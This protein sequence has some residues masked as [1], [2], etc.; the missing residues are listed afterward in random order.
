MAPVPQRRAIPRWF[1][2]L[3]VRSPTCPKNKD[4]L[5]SRF[6]LGLQGVRWSGRQDSNLRPLGPEGPNADPHGLVPGHLASY[7]F[8]N[9]WV[10]GDAGS[11]TVAP[12]PP[13][14]TPF[15]ALVVHDAVGRLLT[16]REV[17]ARLR[18][19]RATVYRLVRAGA[20]PVLRV[21]NA[22]RIPA[23]ALARG[24]LP[25]K[26]AMRAQSDELEGLRVGLPVDEQEV[27]P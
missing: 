11:H 4:A 10:E 18:V 9:T 16:V 26:L 24:A 1:G 6:L 8:D 20:L 27:R 13:V 17:A 2:A 12:L 15:G 3:V 5:K 21:S 22:I 19:S 14:A 7:P 25:E 23:A